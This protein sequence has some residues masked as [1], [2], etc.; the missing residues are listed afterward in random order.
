MTQTDDKTANMEPSL[1]TPDGSVHDVK[2]RMLGP[3]HGEILLHGL[4]IA[5]D[6]QG[7]QVTAMPGDPIPEVVLMLNARAASNL[8]YEGMARVVVGEAP[9]PG[10]AA[11]TFLEAMDPELLEQK[12][13]E[14]VHEFP[15]RGG[16]T[17]A[18]LAVL[19]DWA[20]GRA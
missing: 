13:M 17:A 5:S 11:A 1:G 20:N 10:P 9:D 19:R 14:R 4:D 8:V 7:F 16:T 18:I 15:G 2:I 3:G 12:A 6:V